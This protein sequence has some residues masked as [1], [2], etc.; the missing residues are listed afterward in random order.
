MSNFTHQTQRS[1]ER[2]AVIYQ[3][4]LSRAAALM[5]VIIA[6]S[7]FM[8][9]I[10][11]LEAVAHAGSRTA[12]ERAIRDISTKLSVLEGQYLEATQALTPTRAKALGFVTPEKVS[13]VY[14]KG[15]DG[16]LSFGVG[17]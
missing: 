17:R 9:G 14:T 11:L 4:Y 6:V 16:T 12:A 7:A 13:T 1:L 10:F 2:V 8:Y 3:P 5:T 15:T